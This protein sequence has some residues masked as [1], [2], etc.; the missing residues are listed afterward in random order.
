VKEVKDLRNAA[1][2]VLSHSYKREEIYIVKKKWL[3]KLANAIRQID[4]ILREEKR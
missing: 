1:S 3:D 4:A 2:D